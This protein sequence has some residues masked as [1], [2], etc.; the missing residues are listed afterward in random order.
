MSQ[1]SAAVIV[2]LGQKPSTRVNLARAQLMHLFPAV[3]FPLH[4]GYGAPP[5]GYRQVEAWRVIPNR[6]S[7]R[8]LVPTDPAAAARLVVS[9][10]ALR[11]PRVAWTR[12]AAA[13]AMR[14]LAGLAGEQGLLR[15]SVPTEVS[16][17]DVE[18]G[19]ITVHLARRVPA[20]AAT[21]ISLRDFHPRA[22]PTV[23][24]ADATGRVAAFAKVASDPASA[25]P[26]PAPGRPCRCPECSIWV[27]AVRSPS[28]WSNRC[29]TP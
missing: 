24:I 12:R 19:V 22:K 14:P 4:L 26:W 10:N 18:N 23:Q 21:A 25:L 13:L 5:S 3:G 8:F 28:P 17:H 9:H 2:E 20:A 16:P 15:L 11:P 29:R 27:A 7:P 1:T 6:H